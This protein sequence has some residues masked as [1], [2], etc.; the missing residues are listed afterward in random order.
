MILTPKNW[1]EFQHYKDRAPPWIKLHKKL[2]DDRAYQSLPLA[3]RALAPMLWL[4]ASE[5]KDGSFDGAHEEL[6]FRLRTN[7]KDIAAGLK[8]LIDKGFF[9][10]V[11]NAS[12]VPADCQQLAVPETEGETEAKR[13]KEAEAPTSKNSK[14]RKTGIPDDFGISERV[15]VWAA[16]E[17]FRDLEK[18]LE[19]FVRKAN[20]KGYEYV[21]WDDAFMEAIREDWAKLRGRVANGSAPPADHASADELESRAAIEKQ[22]CEKGL[23]P[24]DCLKEQF[25]AYRERVLRAPRLPGFN[26]D[27]LAARAPKQGASA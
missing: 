7:I 21:K 20:A 11:Q 22:G 19:A 17:G 8:P 10:V 23:G 1:A 4:L 12:G 9:S 13:E 14:G 3:S 27:Q 18:H 25:S 26:L 24:W 2:L 6:A 15:R 16:K 5:S